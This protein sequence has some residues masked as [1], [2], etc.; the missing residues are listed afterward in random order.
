MQETMKTVR[1]FNHDHTMVH[2]SRDQLQSMIWD[3]STRTTEKF[4][5]VVQDQSQQI[6]DDHVHVQT[7]LLCLMVIIAYFAY[8]LGSLTG[9]NKVLRAR[10]RSEIVAPYSA[11]DVGQTSQSQYFSTLISV[12]WSC[13]NTVSQRLLLIASNLYL[14]FLWVL[15]I[16]VWSAFTIWACFHPQEW[17]SN[18]WRSSWVLPWKLRTFFLETWLSFNPHWSYIPLSDFWQR[19]LGAILVCC[20][21]PGAIITLLGQLYG[22]RVLRGRGRYCKNGVMRL[23]ALSILRSLMLSALSVRTEWLLISHSWE[24]L[25]VFLIW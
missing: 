25:W 20:G 22:L 21:A 9:E 19:V 24:I 23:C 6:H 15:S 13:C 16:P 17:P 10:V 18:I 11:D 3:H 5:E 1:D 12:F 8:L 14:A 7:L 2:L 4:I